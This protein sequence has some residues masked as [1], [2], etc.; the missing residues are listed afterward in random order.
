[1]VHCADE[2][3]AVV[4]R[5]ATDVVQA[6]HVDTEDLGVAHQQAEEATERVVINNYVFDIACNN[7]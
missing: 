3:A 2:E 7:E 6:D 5:Q 4:P 1:M